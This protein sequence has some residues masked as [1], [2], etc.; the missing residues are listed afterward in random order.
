MEIHLQC[1]DILLELG[2]GEQNRGSS[3]SPLGERNVN[4]KV[5]KCITMSCYENYEGNANLVQ[6]EGKASHGK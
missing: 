3:Y 5:N 6:K 2:F 1:S 4:Q